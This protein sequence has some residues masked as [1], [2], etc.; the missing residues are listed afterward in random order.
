V[1][2]LT[3]PTWY[4]GAVHRTRKVASALLPETRQV[5]HVA[6]IRTLPAYLE[7]DPS[8]VAISDLAGA[9]SSFVVRCSRKRVESAPSRS[10][11][12]SQPFAEKQ[13]EVVANFA[14][15]AVIAI[16]NARLLNELAPT[17]QRPL[18]IARRPPTAQDRLVQ[19]EKMASLGPAHRRHRA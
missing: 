11:A 15:Q 6:D 17:H 8:V 5:V 9:T 7:G 19:T 14:S 18:K 10:T 4:E 13:T 12:E 3:P 1:P 16:E 2:P